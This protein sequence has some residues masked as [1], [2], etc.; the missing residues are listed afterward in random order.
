[1]QR[2]KSLLVLNHPAISLF[3]YRDECGGHLRYFQSHGSRIDESLSKKP[4]KIVCEWKERRSKEAVEKSK[5][6]KELL[7]IF[8]RGGKIGW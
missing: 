5:R 7:I 1:M 8:N 2:E 3:W 4:C 6:W